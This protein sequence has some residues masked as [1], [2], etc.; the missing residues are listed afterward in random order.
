M[1]SSGA[2]EE[3]DPALPGGRRGH[4]GRGHP[5]Q[6]KSLLQAPAVSR[7]VEGK[8]TFRPGAQGGVCEGGDLGRGGV[9]GQCTMACPGAHLCSS[10]LGFREAPR[11][12]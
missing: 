5:S 8:G 3:K 4:Q 6:P 9:S 7:A 10:E 2:A 12:L 11:W 1:P